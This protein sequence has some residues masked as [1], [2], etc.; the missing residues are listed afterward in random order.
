[1]QFKFQNCIAIVVLRAISKVDK[2]IN[3]SELS[4][5]HVV[6]STGLLVGWKGRG[7]GGKEEIM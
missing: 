4:A 7:D 2:N 6:A 5:V 1:M 3:G